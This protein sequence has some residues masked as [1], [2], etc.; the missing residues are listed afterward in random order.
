VRPTRLLLAFA[1]PASLMTASPVE[2]GGCVKGAVIGGVAGHF[3]HHHAVAGAAVGCVA[4]HYVFRHRSHRY[5]HYRRY[6]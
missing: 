2:A 4:G 1:L 5:H 3:M 6:R